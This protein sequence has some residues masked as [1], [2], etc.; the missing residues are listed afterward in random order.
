MTSYQGLDAIIDTWTTKFEDIM[1]IFSILAIFLNLFHIFVLSRRMMTSSAVTSLLIGIAVVDILSPV[2]YVKIGVKDLIFPG[3]CIP[4]R[5]YF[6]TVFNWILLA[7]RDNCR[8][9]STWFGLELAAI[10]MLSL[11]LALRKQF[12]FIT[13]SPFGLKT[14]VITVLV[15]CGISIFYVFR[16]QVVPDPDWIF[17]PGCHNPR[18]IQYYVDEIE[19]NAK[20]PGRARQLHL[21]LTAILEK[22]LPSFLF[23]IIGVVLICELGKARKLVEDV[24]K[25]STSV[26]GTEKMNKLVIHMTLTFIIIE[27]PIGICKLL[28]AT[29]DSYEDAVIPESITKLFNMI[30]VPMTATHCF[31]C[32]R[33]SSQYRDTVRRILRMKKASVHPG[34]SIGNSMGTA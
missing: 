23:P 29:K 18:D 7:I 25:A 22:I 17:I 13:E 10:R 3:P 8:R 12:N 14:I 19:G 6:E 21:L 2:Y 11:K 28:T 9:C 34:S 33:M 31:I 26:R 27:F 20:A 4:P 30:Y 15:S 16:Y 24:R 5:G 32:Y 1:Y